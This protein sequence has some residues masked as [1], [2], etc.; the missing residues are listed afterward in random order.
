MSKAKRPPIKWH[1]GKAYLAQRI[2]AELAPHHT[3][4]EPYGGGASVLLNKPPSL[5]EVYNDLDSRL[6]RLFEVLRDHWPEFM[7]RLTVTPYAEA[8]FRVHT[9]IGGE[10]EG[11]QCAVDDFVEWRQSIGGRG[12]AWSYTLHRSRRGMADVVS[13]W[14]STI[15]DVLPW[16]VERLRRVQITNR[17]AIEVIQKWDSPQTLH[18]CDPPYVAS[19][20]KSPKVYRHEMSE[21]DHAELGKTKQRK[22]ECLWLNY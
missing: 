8:N 14:L 21:A 19:T 18:Y 6:V 4:V 16:V 20:R 5:V 11:I 15:D 13:G 2:V 1:G 9:Y 3:Y 7:R 12:E 10:D 17:V 22:T